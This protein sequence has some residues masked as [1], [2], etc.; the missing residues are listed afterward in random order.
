MIPPLTL[1]SYFLNMIK[2]I[3]YN[4][5]NHYFSSFL[6]SLFSYDY[7]D[8]EDRY[9]LTQY[10]FNS[11]YNLFHYIIHNEYADPQIVCPILAVY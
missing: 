6:S 9:T 5:L 1:F 10:H 3:H 11:L 4:S 7:S 8:S 2:H